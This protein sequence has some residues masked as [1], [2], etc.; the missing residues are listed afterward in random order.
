MIRYMVYANS[1]E[2]FLLM[3]VQYK[4]EW[5]YEG[6]PANLDIIYSNYNAGIWE[7]FKFITSKGV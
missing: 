6:R 3:F 5:T 7:G 1:M 2:E 4:M